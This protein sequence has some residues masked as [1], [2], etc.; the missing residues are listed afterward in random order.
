MPNKRTTERKPVPRRPLPSTTR[1]LGACARTEWLEVTLVLRRKQPL[2]PAHAP[3]DAATFV[4]RHGADAADVERL[5][6]FAKAHNLHEQHCDMACRTLRLGGEAQAMR[7]AFKVHLGRYSTE[8]GGRTY[9]VCTPDPARPDPAVIAVLGLD[10]RPI[11]HP[12]FRFARAQPRIS[13]TPVQIGAIYHFPEGNGSG[14]NIAIIELGGGYRTADLDRYFRTLGLALPALTAVAVD[15]G[16]NQP[17]SDA[18][19]EVMLDIE[20]IGALVPRAGLYVYFAPNTDQGF[21]DAIAQA[22]HHGNPATNI[23]SISWGGPEG[24]WS[25]DARSAMES[26]LEDAASLGITVC[27][28]AGDSGSSDGD[29]N[30]APSVDY[31]ASSPS[32]L[33]CGGTRLIASNGVIESEVVWNEEAGGE[34]A[35]GGGVSAAFPQPVWQADAKVPPA[36]GGFKGRG[37]PDVAANADPLTGY[38]VL[39]DGRTQVVGGTSAVAPLWS[40]LIARLNQ[41]PAAPVG[42]ANAILY[43]AD[44]KGFLDITSGNNGA[45]Q[46]R[47]GWDPCTGWGSPDGAALPGLF[48]QR[49]R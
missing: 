27:V 4:D 46:A 9:I 34:G 22:T 38:E 26:A 17:G 24:S 25:A 28:A 21:Y 47:A 44:G 45:W 1:H 36:P 7:R 15:G 31:P 39:V 37:V 5:R 30:G 12:H 29:S 40:A 18:D 43:Q 2:K 41:Q 49:R 13:Y 32:V 10:A 3:L 8:P 48:G 35:T 42:A 6:A 23:I 33:G 14:Q 20:I 11:A 16:G 19:G